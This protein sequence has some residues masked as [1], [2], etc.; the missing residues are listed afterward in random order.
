MKQ[1]GEL[2]G[3]SEKETRQRAKQISETETTSVI[4]M[5]GAAAA[6][7]AKVAKLSAKRH[8]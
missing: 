5:H 4:K 1:T 6:I 8:A 7:N 3:E 2:N